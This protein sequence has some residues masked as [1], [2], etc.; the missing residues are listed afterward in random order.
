MNS[1]HL[2]SG[3]TIGIMAFLILSIV[4]AA[5]PAQQTPLDGAHNH[6]AY[7]TA[8][9]QERLE[10]QSTDAKHDTQIASALATRPISSSP[11]HTPTPTNTPSATVTPTATY[12]AQ[13]IPLT[14]TSE[15][16]TA[17]SATPV[18]HIPTVATNTP[19]KTPTG[20]FTTPVATS[21]L[22]DA[23]YTCR[24]ITTSALTRRL[25]PAPSAQSLGVVPS[26]TTLTI[27][28][29]D[30]SIPFNTTFWYVRVADSSGGG[31]LLYARIDP[32][33]GTLEPRVTENYM[34]PVDPLCI[35]ALLR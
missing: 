5:M 35:P 11:T 24:I 2:L 13:G 23:S 20:A 19:T 7:D 14:P 18:T 27:H 10:R 32:A 29:Y 30:G 16:A 22:P 34:T 28:P 25:T 21:P 31:W 17:L 9:A 33:A 1:K 4:V 3:A 26:G 12:T 6:P 8:I 15:G